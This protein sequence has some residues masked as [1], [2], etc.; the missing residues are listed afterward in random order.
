[1][2]AKDEELEA[3]LAELDAPKPAA[4]AAPAAEAGGKK[5]KKKGK[6]EW[7]WYWWWCRLVSP[8]GHDSNW[9]Q[10]VGISFVFWYSDGLAHAPCSS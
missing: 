4:P 6:S 7:W 1:V 3:L 2:S 8:V 5:K 10:Q 9:D